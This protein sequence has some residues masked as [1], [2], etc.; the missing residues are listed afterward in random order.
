MPQRGDPNR[1]TE[2]R[3]TAMMQF[4][5]RQIGCGFNPALKGAIM[6]G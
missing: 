6:L 4:G 1:H 3:L 2:L 5:Q